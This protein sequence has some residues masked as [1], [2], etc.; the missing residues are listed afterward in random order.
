[1]RSMNDLGRRLAATGA[2]LLVLG[3]CADSVTEA[4]AR[5]AAAAAAAV[6]DV[7]VEALPSVN[8][9]SLIDTI[10]NGVIAD[11][12]NQYDIPS[13]NAVS[14]FRQAVDSVL[15]GR[16]VGAD[17]Q[18]DFYGYD[19]YRIRESVS[20]DTMIIF[21]ERVN[22]TTG[23]V[24]RGWGTYA[25]NPRH[26]RRTDIEVNHPVSDQHTEDIG[27]ELYRDCRCRWFAM[28]GAER[29]ANHTDMSSDVAHYTGGP[30]VFNHVHMH[31]H[32]TEAHENA[33]VLSLHG[34]LESRHASL[35]DS[36]DMV[37]SNGRS[38]RSTVPVY[39]T[40]EPVLRTRLRNGGW[41]AGLFNVDAGY[42]ELG[43][44]N[45]QGRWDNNNLGFGHWMHIEIERNV[46]EDPTRWRAM[47]TIIRQ[48]IL[49]F[50]T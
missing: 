28:A 49:D 37:L 20:G 19:V 36:V 29:D 13:I 47:N 27:A 41:E 38:A 10:T 24:P 23:R 2:A 16:W 1:M 21:R 45:L 26:V 25:Y 12:T 32:F 42:N 30:T 11:S 5:V 44:D 17:R 18:L 3:A 9:R 50:P 14:A 8:F 22:A 39:G 46:R 48:W 4:P 15:A 43:G 7:S 33:R 40:S 34:F 31:L 6:E 35:P